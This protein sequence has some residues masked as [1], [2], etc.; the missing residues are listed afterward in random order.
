MQIQSSSLRVRGAFTLIEL[1][2]VIA[3]IAILASL[4]LPALQKAKQ[5]ACTAR[6]LS[7]LRQTGLAMLMYTSDH[8]DK[9]PFTKRPWEYIFFIDYWAL[10]HPYGPTNGNFYLCPADRGPFNYDAVKNERFGTLPIRTND[11]PFLNSYYYFHAFFTDEKTLNT[12]QRRVSEVTYPSRKFVVS[13]SSIAAGKVNP[14]QDP[15]PAH[16]L[17]G[18]PYLFVDGHAAD[19]SRKRRN[20]DLTIPPGLSSTSARLSHQDIP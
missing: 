20:Y 7:N 5:K 4:L 17:D 12:R 13:C 1:L 2:V 15:S 11:L 14:N 3:I 16:R 6:C 10:I 8:D 18:R 9:F 19:I